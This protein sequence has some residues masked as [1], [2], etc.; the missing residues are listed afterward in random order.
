MYPENTISKELKDIQNFKILLE[1]FIEENIS[2]TSLN[3][4]ML[5]AHFNMSQSSLYRKVKKLTNESP[6][7]F[8]RTLRLSKASKLLTNKKSNINDISY[9]VGFTSA[10]Y[11]TKCFKEKYKILPSEINKN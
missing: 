9:K 8:I 10:A 2:N 5:C 3:V 6:N 4:K 11:F 7:Q 1:Q